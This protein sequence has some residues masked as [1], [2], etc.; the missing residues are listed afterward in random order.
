M[1]KHENYFHLSI[2]ATRDCLKDQNICDQG[3]L[4][5]NYLKRRKEDLKENLRRYYAP[6]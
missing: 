5:S 3:L 6:P 4:T 2:I 1:P